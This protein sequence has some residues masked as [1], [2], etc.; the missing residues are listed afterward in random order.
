M[1][2]IVDI[3][4]FVGSHS[5][6][7]VTSF[8]SDSAVILN[9]IAV[10]SPWR[11]N[12]F[13][14]GN[15]YTGSMIF[16]LGK[17]FYLLFGPANTITFINLLLAIFIVVGF[18][19]PILTKNDRVII[20]PLG[21]FFFISALHSLPTEHAQML[22]LIT[23]D[24]AHR[25]DFLLL[26]NGAVYLS[27]MNFLNKP[28]HLVI[29]TILAI[30]SSWVNFIA[31]PLLAAL[32]LLL[33]LL[34]FFDNKKRKNIGGLIQTVRNTGAWPWVILALTIIMS[35]FLEKLSPWGIGQV[36]KTASWDA[37]KANFIP[38]TRNIYEI[39]PPY[40]WIAS[41]II[42]LFFVILY[43][44][45]W[46]KQGRDNRIKFYFYCWSG[47][48]SLAI[49][50]TIIPF[51]KSWFYSNIV[52]PRY[53][54]LGL[55][56]FML[57]ASVGIIGIIHWLTLMIFKNKS[58]TTRALFVTV[59]ALLLTISIVLPQHVVQKGLPKSP[60]YESGE[61]I[62]RHCEGVL[63]NYWNSYVYQLG[64]F[65]KLAT[66]S[67]GL[68]RSRTNLARTLNTT[69]LCIVENQPQDFNVEYTVWDNKLI[70]TN[71]DVVKLP[72]GNYFRQYGL[73]ERN[74]QTVS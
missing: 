10:S 28:N 69:P 5:R 52:L 2:P 1:Y 33:T 22:E 26:F 41:I 6:G 65:G 72:D 60:Q 67:Y 57:S 18:S 29:L 14:W 21:L 24:L 74:Q 45:L 27:V 73:A 68:D 48:F 25:P 4:T 37:I 47:L 38:A 39:F 17:A 11:E 12:I 58:N 43:A 36:L 13:F 59:I 64:G 42:S 19:V 30:L 40:L 51:T 50:A 61:F 20:A 15:G 66:A 62:A 54:V 9:M 31:I 16:L 70:T 44:H 49:I 7:A 46:L 8:N 23:T 35:V 71:A 53:T 3:T 55:E 56:L 32:F 63:G 34:K